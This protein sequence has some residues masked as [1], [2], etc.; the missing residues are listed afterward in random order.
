VKLAIR[1]E[2]GRIPGGGFHYFL[3]PHQELGEQD[4]RLW[5]ALGWIVVEVDQARGE[6]LLSEAGG[7]LRHQFEIARLADAAEAVAP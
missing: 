4:A 1:K 3:A 5:A 7:A 6:R 2:E